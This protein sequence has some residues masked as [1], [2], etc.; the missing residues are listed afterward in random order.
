MINLEFDTDMIGADE[1]RFGK[2]ATFIGFVLIMVCFFAGAAWASGEGEKRKVTDFRGVTV[3]VPA[4]IERI[5]TI[6]DGLVEQV[7]SI[8]GESKKIVGLGSSSLR[9]GSAYKL[10]DFSGNGSPAVKGVNPALF[11]N[12]QFKDL[13]LV[14]D[15]STA[16]NLETL[17]GLD[18][19]VVV[20][21][22]G[23][24]SASWEVSDEASDKNLSSIESLGFPV[25][26]VY[27]PPLLNPPTPSGIPEEIKTIGCIF[28][29]EEKAA[30]IADYIQGCVDKIK[31]RTKNVP[32][33]EKPTVLALGLSP[34]SRK[35]GGAGNV[36]GGII[37]YYIEAVA[38]AKS[39]YTVDRY[40][41]DMGV[42]S[43]EHVLAMD[44]DIIILPTSSGYHPPE[45]LYDAPYYEKLRELKAVKN[46]RVSALPYMPRNCDA[47][48]LEFV[49]DLMI[50]AKTA[51]P[52]RFKDIKVHEWALDYFMNVYGVDKATAEKIRGGLWL[53]WMV[54]EDF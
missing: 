36:R 47:S 35:A 48:R 11:L 41:S 52:E 21:R 31:D 43:T 17:A 13:P 24:C 30:Q 29:K 54:E 53:D 22:L 18:P 12:P 20:V 51:Y 27:A 10:P 34:S 23:S 9:R 16:V 6:D 38:N 19:D 4:K 2:K 37:E 25:V 39:A 33:N 7:L 45:E 26:A 40:T 44:P 50:I 32:E 3:E 42:V 14:K 1:M 5:V 46:R 49:L 15:S 28:G 8:L